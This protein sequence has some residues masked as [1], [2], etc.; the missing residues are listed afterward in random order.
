MTDTRCE[1][2]IRYTEL[3]QRLNAVEWKL[4]AQKL[5]R[6]PHCELL[7]PLGRVTIAESRVEP[8]QLAGQRFLL[9]NWRERLTSNRDARK[10]MPTTCRPLHFRELHR[11]LVGLVAAEVMREQE[12][13]V[14]FRL[15]PQS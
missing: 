2:L 5:L 7:R 1:V 12:I 9:L 6:R 10:I 14:R 4:F 15:G 8:W 11:R 13:E 3:F